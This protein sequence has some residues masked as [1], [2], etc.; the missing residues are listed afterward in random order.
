M[1][2]IDFDSRF[3]DYVK[4]WMEEHQDDY[5]TMDEMEQDVPAV[6]AQ[7]LDTPADWLDGEKPGEYFERYDD[8]AQ[9]IDWM[10][11]YL[12]QHVPVPDMLLNRI[13]DLG[14]RAAPGLNALLSDRAATAEK[15]ML[16]VTLLR[17]IG[18]LL[19]LET[20]VDWQLERSLE[21]E[22]CDNALDS[23][24]QM[25]ETARDAMLEALP[26]AN[27][28]GR[29]ALLSVLTRLPRDERVFDV[30]MELFDLAPQR[31]AILSAYLGRLGDDRAL[32]RLLEAALEE[33]LRYLDYIELRAAI[34][35]LGGEAPE[36]EFYSDPEYEA[37][38]GLKP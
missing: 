10:S 33:D 22:L 17:E 11:D 15:Q 12:R 26:A 38:Q 3:G 36:R 27:E 21:D 16:A 8:P 2:C 13:S 34:E 1:K 28:A 32:P 23:L 4:H 20:Y 30:L 14:E 6:Y 7:F 29:E 31:R 9:L 24:E 25:G 18:S 5:A 35:A 19:P 37:L